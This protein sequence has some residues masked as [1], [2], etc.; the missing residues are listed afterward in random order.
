MRGRNAFT[1]I[2]LLVV[3]ATGNEDLYRVQKAAWGKLGYE[4]SPSDL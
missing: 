4:P 3:T 2:E 1:L